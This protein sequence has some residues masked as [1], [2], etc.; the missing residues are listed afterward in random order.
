ML[1]RFASVRADLALV[2]LEDGV[3]AGEKSAAR[4]HLR[5][6]AA[7]GLLEGT[8]WAL[9][10]NPSESPEHE[11]D[12]RLAAAIRAP[13]VVLPKAERTGAVESMSGRAR[14]FGAWTGLVV[15]TAK[16]V[17][18]V[19]DLAA[20]H[21]AIAILLVG[22]AD[23]RLSLRARPDEGRRFELHALGEVLLAARAAGAAA[24]D[25][26]YFRYRDAEGLRRD[27]ALARDLGYDGK[28]AIHPDQIPI[29]HEV[30]APSAAE[31]EW[32]RAVIDGWERLAGER[33]GVV[34]VNGEMIEAL[35][36]TLARR[37]LSRS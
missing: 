22:S 14:E 29:L 16:G 3:A 33:H 26:V 5:D 17:R 34:V 21:P 20:C 25:G 36:V 30:F 1:E 28:S 12:L 18:E 10:V 27:A 15:E 32:A 4:E 7:R 2:D 19:R 24:V 11:P 8:P 37:I 9:R 35:H 23:L 6:A 13:G 31:I